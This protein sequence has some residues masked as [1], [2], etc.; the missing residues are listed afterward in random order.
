MLQTTI[1]NLKGK[2]KTHISSEI[3]PTFNK[4]SPFTTDQTLYCCHHTCSPTGMQTWSCFPKNA[5]ALFDLSRCHNIR[6]YPMAPQSCWK[7]NASSHNL[8]IPGVKHKG[9]AFPQLCPCSA[10]A[11][12]SEGLQ[13]SLY[14]TQWSRECHATFFRGLQANCEK[15]A[16]PKSSKSRGKQRAKP[17][18][19]IQWNH[20]N[21]H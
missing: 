7:R 21:E 8:E 14:K 5:E 2:T 16:Y 1:L 15:L 20:S 18:A 11:T 19:G 6:T 17:K 13:M 4:R 9:T 12:L 3:I 10:M